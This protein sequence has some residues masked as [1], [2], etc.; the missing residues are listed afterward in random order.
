M[1]CRAQMNADRARLQVTGPTAPSWQE[2]A[3]LRD[4]I[5]KWERQIEMTQTQLDEILGLKVKPKEEPPKPPSTLH[6][7]ILVMLDA[8]PPEEARA[9]VNDARKQRQL[10]E[11]A[12]AM[13]IEQQTS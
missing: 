5:A 1:R 12:K 11:A 13:T 4:A 9:L 3:S 10:V 6:N 8:M 2:K 7:N